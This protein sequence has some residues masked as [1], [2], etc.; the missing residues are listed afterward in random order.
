MK[1]V[2]PNSTKLPSINLCTKNKF[3][4]LPLSNYLIHPFQGFNSFQ[5]FHP[6]PPLSPIFKSQEI[7]PPSHRL[8]IIFLTLHLGIVE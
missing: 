4:L 2:T 8:S 5:S 3:A 6:L 1:K 7:P